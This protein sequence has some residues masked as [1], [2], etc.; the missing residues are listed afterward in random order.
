MVWFIAS[1]YGIY[2]LWLYMASNVLTSDNK[3]AQISGGS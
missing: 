1:V 2:K 3:T